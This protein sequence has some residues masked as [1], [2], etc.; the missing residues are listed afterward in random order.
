MSTPS[1]VFAILTL[2]ILAGSVFARG[3]GKEIGYIEDF[4]LAPDREK[5]LEKLV[6]GTRDYYYY[7]ALHYQNTGQ[8]DKV[9]D[10]L[11]VWEERHRG[12]NR[13]RVIENRQILLSYDV[14]PDD[15]LER[16]RRRLGV[17][18][19][20]SRERA[21]ADPDRSSTLDPAAITRDRFFSR[22]RT[23]GRQSV[24]RFEPTAYD[25][26]IREDL[27]AD[28]RR[29][30]LSQLDHPDYPDLPAIIAADLDY[31][32][33]RG[34]GHHDVHKMLTIEQ[35]ENLL[36]IKPDLH[37]DSAF[38]RT[39]LASLR[40]GPDV[41]IER[42]L[43]ERR[44]YLER[45]WG[46]AE[47]LAPASNALKLNILHHRLK[48]DRRM[49][50]HDLDRFREYV[51]IP[52]HAPYINEDWLERQRRRDPDARADP[53][54]DYREATLLPP[55][56]DDQP[57]VRA[58]LSHFFVQEDRRDA[59]TD[60]LRK[61]YLDRVF[62]EA[63]LMAGV[64]DPEALYS[65]LSPDQVQQLRDR[66]DIDF[67]P[68]NPETFKPGDD[69]TLGAKI[70]NVDE[71]LIRIYRVNELNYY[72]DEK[73]Q[74]DTTIPLDGLVPSHELKHEY[75]EPPIRRIRR[76]FTFEQVDAPG[77]WVVEMIGGG[78][79]SR[80]VIRKGQLRYT[81]RN[82]PAGHIF[83]IYDQ[84]NEPRPQATLL[85]D[86]REFE[87]DADGRI[88][89]P[90]T[91]DPGRRKVILV[92][93]DR[94][95]LDAFDHSR[96]TYRFDA[97]F[98]LE[99][100]LINDQQQAELLIRPTL[101]LNGAVQPIGLLENVRLNIETKDLDGVTSSQTVKDFELEEGR[102]T[103]HRFQV[104]PRVKQLKVSLEATISS[105]SD[106]EE[107][108]LSA[109]ETL[110][111][112]EVRST[113]RLTI[114]YLM[115]DGDDHVLEVR[116]RNGE[117][118]SNELV[119][120]R[121]W[122]RDVQ[123]PHRSR[124][125][126][127]E[128]GRV[129]L[130][131][132][133]EIA[134]LRVEMADG[135]TCDWTLHEPAYSYEATITGRPGEPLLVPWMLAS[136]EPVK[137]EVG[138][139][140]LRDGKPVADRF[141]DLEIEDGYLVLRNLDPGDYKL[142]LKRNDDRISVHITE[143]VHRDGHILGDLRY[144]ERTDPQPMALLRPQVEDD[145]VRIGTRHAGE[146]TRVHIL[147]SRYVDAF[148]A[149]ES[150]RVPGREAASVTTLPVADSLY[151]AG[152]DIG[153]EYRYIL[154]R[155]SA[156]RYP[157]NMLIR[158]GL[159][160]NPWAVRETETG[161]LHAAPEEAYERLARH[162]DREQRRRAEAET[163]DTERSDPPDFNFLARP[164]VVKANLR[165]D[166][167]GI[168]EFDRD[169]LGD[170]HMLW[171]VAVDGTHTAWRPLALEEAE[172]ARREQRLV[173]SLDVE[174]HFIQRR[175][176][177][178]LEAGDELSFDDLT[179]AQLETYDSLASVYRL[180]LTLSEQ[181]GEGR[182][183]LGKFAFILEWPALEREEQ[184]EKYAEFASHELNFFLYHKDRAFFDEVVRPYLAH[185]KDKTFMD[186]Y[187]LG[188][189]LGRYTERWAF[190]QLNAVERILLGRR[191]EQRER[192]RRHIADLFD[193]IPP[194][195]DRDNRLFETALHGGAL[196]ME[197][198]ARQ[199]EAQVGMDRARRSEAAEFRRD[200]PAR[201]RP[202]ADPQAMPDAAPDP[203][204]E[205]LLLE[206]ELDDAVEQRE[207]IRRFYREV[208]PTIEWAENN[209]YHLRIDEQDAKLVRPNAFWRDYA[210]H[211]DE[212]PFL[213]PKL[214]EAH[215]NFTEIML[216]LA[217]LDLPFTA[218]EHEL[219]GFDPEAEVA[220]PVT[221]KAASPVIAYHRQ[222][223]PVEPPRV[224]EEV[225]V[226]VSQNFF[227]LDDRYRKVDDERVDKFITDEF[228]IQTVYGA[229]VVVTN[230][231]S[232]P[233]RVDVL[234]QVP[235]GAVPV[236]GD[237]TLRSRHVR[238]EAF[239][240]A[241]IE[242]H[243]YFLEPGDYA[244]YP[245][246]V[247]ERE[248]LAAYAEPLR[249]NVVAEPT[250]IDRESWDYISQ[251]GS[252][253]E[254]IEFLE[255][256]NVEDI[257]LER[258]AWR[259]QDREFFI[260]TIELLEDR[261]AYDG[262]LWSYG[263]KHDHVPAIRQYLQHQDSFVEQCGAYLDSTLLAIDPVQRRAW[264]LLEYDPLVNARAHQL[265]DRRRIAN[266]A[267]H[268]QY[269]DMLDILAYKDAL[270]DDD[271]MTISYYM[272]LQG[273]TAAALDFFGK[274]EPD[275]LDTQLQYD[276]FKAYMAFFTEDLDVAREIAE[277]RAD[278]P[279][280][281]WRKRFEMVLEHLEQIE[282]RA[283]DQLADAEGRDREHEQLADTDPAIEVA[284]EG[285]RIEI[286][287]ANVDSARISYYL[288]DI[289]LLFSNEPFVTDYGGRFGYV[290]PNHRDTIELPGREGTETI[291]LP[292]DLSGRN[293]MI[294]VA[295]AGVRRQAAYFSNRLEVRLMENYGQLRVRQRGEDRGYGGVYVKVYARMADGDVRF[296][297]DG[298]TDLRGRFD[299]ASVSGEQQGGVKEFAIL[300]M[301]DEHGAVVREAPAPRR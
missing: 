55:V 46:F 34:F 130:G 48:L 292:D 254:V 249:F 66:V 192:V 90:Y 218:E 54:A 187:M 56:G 260:K 84:D 154:D 158:P 95:T 145:K 100:E 201:G 195:V 108:E 132:L 32:R 31:E 20:H 172:P 135:L 191:L 151:V 203:P 268:A 152:R 285:D 166:E 136:D 209:Y 33:S 230:P 24:R 250:E 183:K 6:P 18:F 141:D 80:A 83:R 236:K 112:N 278:H 76:E 246:H 207:R 25:W 79:S 2:L 39:Y 123:W 283:A 62:A 10:L 247:A 204:D 161:E 245:V 193:L 163:R 200:L 74:I 241:R 114:P 255:Q 13:R 242:Y 205:R 119:T 73:E 148:N 67:T 157:G 252:E 208:P 94:A 111:V 226:L 296:Y 70:K 232:T 26:L 86:G 63:R 222:V 206:A 233:R 153:E 300:I 41:D 221:L 97:G 267:V 9:D 234:L 281:R 228:L 98:H 284:V 194:D 219:E 259:M 168:I 214:V 121:L 155:R 44:E 1:R 4:A 238:L 297:K 43:D 107:V 257:N 189:D 17:S 237:R 45:L 231:T 125:Q 91:T 11:K 101:R 99:R 19:T 150:L 49:G 162:R 82:G 105:V 170:R 223:E 85:V 266:E 103:V 273:R 211:E 216:A 53:S 176:T 244:H 271:D 291:E 185:K 264:E 182:E 169:D 288:M 299:Y 295:A 128:R 287:H 60:Y 96:E 61:E 68:D 92:E 262:T 213:S 190:N 139:L 89:V 276:Y 50:I 293:V 282:G 93:S 15:A 12:D 156:R 171:I 120:V 104:P 149:Y 133:P 290:Q 199:F 202:V 126:S 251:H 146:G 274:V 179:E 47:D 224:G 258:I 116:G 286:D 110:E 160:L 138:L 109:T 35:L 175:N 137:E 256:H 289:E 275:N 164:A 159:L 37:D 118:L 124:L 3:G 81:K 127:D 180:M 217:V 263:I 5:V 131:P 212:A 184:L 28:E 27:T 69:V 72:R 210:A 29:D 36:E 102:E 225:E 40:P 142:L 240:T 22:A 173:E 75:D 243:F 87:P 42:D 253:D 198:V 88:V 129:H 174:Q 77:V 261:L 167:D 178:V 186:H 280:D 269:T 7:H 147:A 8:L 134:R 197:G 196:A 51:A 30:L 38:I 65:L 113:D 59:F 23:P 143:G 279:I 239:D 71:L 220:E 115:R 144:L 188:D 78:I 177:D 229:Q 215:G 294:E 265:G 58:Y 301:S 181:E 227:Q 57:L 14:D 298:Y 165:P 270:D 235:E 122:H 248:R 21:D 277:A 272:L 140:E 64:G 106:D 52:R 117:M 16:L